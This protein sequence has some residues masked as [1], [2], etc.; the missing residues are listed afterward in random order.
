MSS[1]LLRYAVGRDPETKKI[2][3]VAEYVDRVTGETHE[4]T[5]K[6]KD[7]A[8]GMARLCKDLAQCIHERIDPTFPKS[9]S[10][11]SDAV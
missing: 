7:I 4:L 10:Q 11:A 6:H 8:P 2:N 1:T 3:I 9:C 5:I